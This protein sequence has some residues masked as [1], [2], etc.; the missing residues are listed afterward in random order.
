MLELVEAHALG[1]SSVQEERARLTR[2]IL[3]QDQHRMNLLVS[4]KYFAGL[5]EEEGLPVRVMVC[6]LEKVLRGFNEEDVFPPTAGHGACGRAEE[7]T[8]GG[9]GGEK[10]EEGRRAWRF[11]PF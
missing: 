7:M 9:K 1:V 4:V 11:G 2:V 10:A 5:R 3:Y 8:A 6:G